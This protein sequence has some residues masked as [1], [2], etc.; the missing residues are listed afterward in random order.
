MAA[1]AHGILTA[2]REGQESQTAIMVCTARAIADRLRI[3]PGFSDPTAL[4]LLPAEARQQVERIAARSAERAATEENATAAPEPDLFIMGRT[5][6]M[7][8][9]TL[10]IDAVLRSRPPAQLVTLGAGLDGRAWRMPEL[11]ESIVF[12]VDHPESQRKKRER[13]AALPKSSREIRFVPVDF[14]RDDLGTA[15]D[16][17]GH[18][19]TMATTWLWEGVVMY[20]TREEIDATMAVVQ[21][22]SPPESRLVIA[23]V[24]S[25]PLLATVSQVVRQVGEPVRSVFTAD[26]MAT[27]LAQ[28]GFAVVDDRTVPEIA[29]TLAPPLAAGTQMV[30]HARMV[31]AVRRAEL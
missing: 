4:T 31:T 30:R 25:G 5:V 13:A 21:R 9:R 28:F 20:L 16:G 3:F 1:G 11:R 18:D 6:M 15:L 8:V 17:A 19:P 22:R 27:L 24:S 12:E 14:S 2:M 23:Y 10:Y 29:A 26:E 7:I